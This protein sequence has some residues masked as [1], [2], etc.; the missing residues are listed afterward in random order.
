VSWLI[1]LVSDFLRQLAS[2]AA[3]VVDFV[4]FVFD[5][6]SGPWPKVIVGGL[7]FLL[8][9]LVVTRASRAR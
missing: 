9:L 5:P 1:D 3:D 8:I 6:N 2:V 7:F 4:F